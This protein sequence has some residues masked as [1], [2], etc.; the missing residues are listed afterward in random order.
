[1]KYEVVQKPS[2][3]QRNFHNPQP[4]LNIHGHEDSEL[5]A[6]VEMS[7]PAEMERHLCVVLR[8]LHLSNDLWFLEQ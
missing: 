4:V 5:S 7:P 8:L 3:S 6:T 2:G 1:M